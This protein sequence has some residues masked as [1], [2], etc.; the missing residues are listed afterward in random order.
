MEQQTNF[1]GTE[2]ISKILLKIAPQL[3]KYPENIAATYKVG[4]PNT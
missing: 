4:I 1:F 3:A 2:K